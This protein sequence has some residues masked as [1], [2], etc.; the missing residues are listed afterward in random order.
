MPRS[1]SARYRRRRAGKRV[2]PP[3]TKRTPD[4][5]VS[6]S[7]LLVLRYEGESHARIF[8]NTA[9]LGLGI[10]IRKRRRHQVKNP[11][12]GCGIDSTGKGLQTCRD[13]E[14]ARDVDRTKSNF[15]EVIGV[16]LG[17][18]T[19]FMPADGVPGYLPRTE[20]NYGQAAGQGLLHDGRTPSCFEVSKRRRGISQIGTSPLK[21]PASI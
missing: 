13:I 4:R 19:S 10:P 9:G 12:L 5:W 1:Y 15:H 2:A 7:S 16:R 17:Q 11:D 21:T 6:A 18:V 20:K 14:A 8:P 3:R